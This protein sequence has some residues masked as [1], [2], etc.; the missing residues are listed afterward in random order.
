MTTSSRALA[1]L[2]LLAGLTLT[3]GC[4]SNDATPDT[5][6]KQDTV[7][8]G[9]TKPGDGKDANA[10]DMTRPTETPK[11]AEDDMFGG[12]VKMDDESAFAADTGTTPK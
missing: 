5:A 11:K 3:V 1:L 9:D 2:C 6:P 8:R 7:A 10:D 4:A 12:A